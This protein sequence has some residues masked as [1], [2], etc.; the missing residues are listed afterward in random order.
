[1]GQALNDSRYDRV[2]TGCHDDGDAAG[3]LLCGPQSGKRPR[4]DDVNAHTLQVRYLFG[5]ELI[6]TACVSCLKNEMLAFNVAEIAHPLTEALKERG[7]GRRS[8][9]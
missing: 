2:G 1:M 5:Q 6:L 9:K 7:R 3:S 8:G 4:H